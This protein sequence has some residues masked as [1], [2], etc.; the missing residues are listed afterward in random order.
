MSM[1]TEWL[2]QIPTDQKEALAN[3]IIRRGLAAPMQR[4][5][6]V[7]RRPSEEFLFDES[8]PFVDI[9]NLLPLYNKLAF[10]ENLLVKGPK[11]NGKSLSFV[12]FAHTTSTPL[13]KVKCSGDT[14]DRH[15]T[16]TFIMRGNRETPF[17][18]GP[19]PSAIDVANEYGRAILVFEEI[20]SLTP[21]VQKQLNELLDFQKEV[22]VSQIN[23]TYRLNKESHLW[24]V[25]TMNPSVYGGTYDVN[26][27][28]RSRFEELDTDYPSQRQEKEV[29]RANVTP[30]TDPS[31]ASGYGRFIELAI[32]LASET[33]Q[34]GLGYSLSSRDV[35]RLVRGVYE[36]GLN[37]NSALQLLASKFEDDDRITIIKRIESIF[38]GTKINK[39][40]GAAQ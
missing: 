19:L 5:I 24:A 11:G 3:E 17:I 32:R 23:K 18:L 2:E 31:V 13:I 21:Q 28:L 15:L 34:K 10:R 16:G 29:V 14:K 22:S 36:L 30:P 20:N 8:P 9:H 12:Y 33:R 40:W 25:A 38:P 35:V 7:E 39:S 4:G 6:S 27:D 26:E 1:W 37:Q